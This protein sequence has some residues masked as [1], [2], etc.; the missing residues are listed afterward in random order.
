M[1]M[2]QNWCLKRIEKNGKHRV[3]ISN[4]TFAQADLLL[5]QFEEKYD[6]Q[7]YCIEKMSEAIPT[8]IEPTVAPS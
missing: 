4:L 8:Q 3:V 6:E 1:M 5:I 7:T 2:N